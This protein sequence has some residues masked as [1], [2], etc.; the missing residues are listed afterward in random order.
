MT[1]IVA[2]DSFKGTYSA[3]QV[4]AAIA[5]GIRRA[6]GSALELPVADGGEGTLSALSTS[7]GARTVPVE[8]VSC[9]GD[10][11]TAEIGVAADGTAI[12]EVASASGLHTPTAGP[13]DPVTAS[14][15]GTG[16]LM[17]RAVD[18]GARRILVAA[19][20]SATTDGGWGA[21]EAIEANGGMRGAK[22]VVLSD[23]TTRY[24][25]AAEVFGPQKGADT[26]TIAL[27]TERLR[28]LA[29][30]LPKDPWDTARTGAAG[31]FSGGMWAQYDAELVSGADYILDL[32][33]LDEHVARARA[34][35]VG[36]GRLDAQTRQGKIVSAIAARSAGLPV[37]AVV[38]SVG[39]D[40]GDYVDVFRQVIVASD[41]AAMTAAGQAIA[42]A[43]AE[44]GIHPR[45]ERR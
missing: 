39:A 15:Y 29:R 5:A 26:A 10:P 11:M 12:I 40:V 42:E 24:A 30:R 38:G 3:D 34:I 18:L 44:A 41:A 16:L 19:G 28:E 45:L 31:G 13:R 6:G 8:T 35:V 37:F 32:L 4:A 9:W 22:V 23:V 27:L 25:A 33:R 14:T 43:V 21:I 2:P 20:G 36:E 7:L 1:V 17:A